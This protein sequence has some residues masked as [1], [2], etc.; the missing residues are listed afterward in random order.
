[1]KHTV[2]PHWYRNAPDGMDEAAFVRYCAQEL[3]ALILA[4]GPDTVAAFIGEPV[5]GTGGI[6]P[7]PDGYWDAI[8]AVLRQYDILL[9]ADEVV[10]GFGRLGTP[11]GSHKYGITPHLVTVAKGLTSAYAPLSG[12]IVGERV[13]DV[14]AQ[15]SQQAGPMGHGWTYSGH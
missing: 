11:M 3:E 12:V 9:I 14:I 7:P 10:C 2:R 5:L 15:G 4:E 6:V 8:Q 1:M 13:W